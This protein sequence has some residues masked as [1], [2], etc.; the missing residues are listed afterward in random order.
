MRLSELDLGSNII[1]VKNTKSGG[2][3]DIP[4]S[5]ELALQLERWI[6]IERKAYWSKN[7]PY[8][9]P[10]KTNKKLR[11]SKALRKIVHKAADK[12]G[13]QRVVSERELTKA[14]KRAQNKKTGVR[15]DYRVTPHTLRHTFAHLLEQAGLSPEA[16]RDAL[17]HDDLSTT[18]DHYSFSESEYEDQIRDLLHDD[19]DM[20]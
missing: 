18:E 8:L 7:N 17:G 11:S 6:R 3:V 10:A 16:R 14:E 4:I 19:K 5:D 1:A 20:D 2:S 15:R 12:A 9:F 13:I